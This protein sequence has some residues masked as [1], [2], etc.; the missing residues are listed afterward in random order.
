MNGAVALSWS[1]HRS[2]VSCQSVTSV[3]N[4]FQVSF[5]LK[6]NVD[7]KSGGIVFEE[8]SRGSFKSEAVD[9]SGLTLPTPNYVTIVIT[10]KII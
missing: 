8:A 10:V 6:I 1:P 9:E 7:F 2:T 4:I 3:A 5:Q